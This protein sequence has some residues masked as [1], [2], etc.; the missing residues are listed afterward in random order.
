MLTAPLF[1]QDE[2]GRTTVF[3]NGVLGRGYVLPDAAAEERVRR[4]LGW[5]MLGAL[6]VGIGGSQVMLF[7]FGNPG[8]WPSTVWAAAGAALMAFAVAYRLF[9]MRLVVGFPS[10]AAQLTLLEAFE[11]QA[12]AM[13]RWYLWL[14]LSTGALLGTGSAVMI[15]TADSTGERVMSLCG[16][17]LFALVFLQAVYGLGWR[18]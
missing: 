4:T 3:P 5:A 14:M 17:L 6:A 10:S 8:Q 1:R 7:L 2:S 12:L 11:R 9:V 13:P 16:A 18:R 15:F